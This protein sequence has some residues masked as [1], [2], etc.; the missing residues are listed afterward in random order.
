M[1]RTSQRRE[2]ILLLS[3]EKVTLDNLLVC[4]KRINS[5][6]SWVCIVSLRSPHCALVETQDLHAVFWM[7]W[8][9]WLPEGW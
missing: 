7:A 9:R 4:G 3:E 8:G 2:R 5:Q 1:L 6:V